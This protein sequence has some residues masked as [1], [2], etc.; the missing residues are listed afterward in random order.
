MCCP[1]KTTFTRGLKNFAWIKP[2]E[3]L[4]VHLKI[5]RPKKTRPEKS[6]IVDAAFRTPFSFFPYLTDNFPFS[7]YAKLGS[8][9]LLVS[10][11]YFRFTIISSGF[12]Q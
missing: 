12:T 9:L 2:P 11:I 3:N 6:N 1:P 4:K 5:R 8:Y 7:F 10:Y